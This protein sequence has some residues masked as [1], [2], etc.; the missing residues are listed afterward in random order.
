MSHLVSAARSRVADTGVTPQ[1]TGE[2][3]ASTFVPYVIPAPKSGG[4]SPILT[5]P[6]YRAVSAF[7]QAKGLKRSSSIRIY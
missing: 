6:R 7:V 4:S 1:S 2:R 5:L 3:F